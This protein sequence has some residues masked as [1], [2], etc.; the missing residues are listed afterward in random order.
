MK[1]PAAGMLLPVDGLYVLFRASAE[2]HG[3]GLINDRP[4][5]IALA[6]GSRKGAVFK[7]V[8]VKCPVLLDGLHYLRAK[9]CDVCRG[10]LFTLTE[11][12]YV[13]LG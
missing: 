12:C 5:V 7:V 9:F 4:P 2:L 1:A 11:V 6:D 8:Q 10:H 13:V 3:S